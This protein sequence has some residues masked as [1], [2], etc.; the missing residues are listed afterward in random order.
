[1]RSLTTRLGLGLTLGLLV[2]F[3]A[4]WWIVT[5]SIRHVAE[6]YTAER[7]RHDL[8]TLSAGLVIGA[9]GPRLTPTSLGPIYQKVFSGHYYRITVDRHVLRSRSLWDE[10]LATPTPAPGAESLTSLTGPQG[11]RLL[12]LARTITI[13][14]RTVVTTVAEDMSALIAD[15]RTFNL[16]YGIVSGTALLLMLLVQAAALRLGLRPLNALRENISRLEH[17]AANTLD[18]PAPRE[19]EPLVRAFNELLAV[20]RRRL[21]HSRRAAGNLAHALKTPL[22]I[23]TDTTDGAAL[24]ERPELRARLVEQVERIGTLIERELKRA[25]LAGHVTTLAQTDLAREL[26]VLRDALAAIYR[27]KALA[28]DV[29]WT[30]PPRWPIDREDFLELAGNL[31]DNACKWATRRARIQIKTE[32]D[33]QLVVD[34]D[35]PGVPPEAL[36]HLVERGTR[37]D[38][39]AAGHGLGLAIARDAAT[40]YGGT[41]TFAASSELGGLQVEVRLPR[42]PAAG[43]LSD[44]G[45]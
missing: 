20:L 27:D 16:R 5:L 24:K 12:V 25:R 7:L 14:N 23:L 4:Q 36:A 38:E 28:I 15:L 43:G 18:A 30:G 35:G 39:S 21:E 10:D 32:N 9:D 29:A 34:D 11:Q 42:R 26:P 41:M 19:I 37:L 2:V 1:M 8:D 22:S 31:L 3:A 45:H 44:T 40:A 17:G 33:L 13:D 6:N